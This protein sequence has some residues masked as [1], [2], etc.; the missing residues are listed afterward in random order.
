VIWELCLAAIPLVMALAGTGVV[1]S[2]FSVYKEK[3]VKPEFK[4]HL[5]LI[6]MFV[7]YAGIHMLIEVQGRYRDFTLPVL[8]ILASGALYPATK[9]LSSNK[10]SLFTCR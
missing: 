5:I 6:L 9:P 8:F 4:L 10:V 1:R 2:A 7:I 3:E